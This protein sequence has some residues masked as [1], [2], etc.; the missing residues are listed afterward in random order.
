M[1]VQ[2]SA[3]ILLIEQLVEYGLLHGLDGVGLAGQVDLVFLLHDEE[4][5]VHVAFLWQSLFRLVPTVLA[6]LHGQA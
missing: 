5:L 1:F 2:G 6:A 4:L 3:D